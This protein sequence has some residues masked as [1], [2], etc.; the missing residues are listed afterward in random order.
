MGAGLPAPPVVR[1]LVARL[2][3]G[4]VGKMSD[5]RV[6]GGVSQLG[7]VPK[8]HS[9][10][11]LAHGL[12]AGDIAHVPGGL[13]GTPDAE[14]TK[15]ASVSHGCIRTRLREPPSDFRGQRLQHAQRFAQPRRPLHLLAAHAAKNGKRG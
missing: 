14:L 8:E 9:R 12:G 4:V 10:A 3:A 7:K 15:N 6:V 5:I 11:L 2:R 1:D 13:V